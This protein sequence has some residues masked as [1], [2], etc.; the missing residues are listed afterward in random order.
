MLSLTNV[1]F[2]LYL[3]KF[4]IRIMSLAIIGKGECGKNNMFNSMKI[5][6]KIANFDMNTD[7]MLD[8]LSATSP[9][10]DNL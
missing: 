3:S 10:A 1:G 4:F 2:W 7:L 8:I 6:L 5:F 9:L